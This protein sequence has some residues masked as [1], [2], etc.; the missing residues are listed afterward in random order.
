MTIFKT[1][2]HT[3]EDALEGTTQKYWLRKYDGFLMLVAWILLNGLQAALTRLDPDEAYYWVYAQALEWGYFDHPPAVAVLIWLGKSLL[4][5][6]LGVR[7]FTVLLMVGTLYGMWILAGKPQDRS[8]LT[9]LAALLV[10]MPFLHIYSFVATPDAPLLFC[11]VW[12]FVCYQRFVKDASWLNTALLG[13][14]MAAMLFSKYHGLLV[15]LFTL[16]SNWRLLLQPRFY[17]ASVFGAVLFLPH[18]YWQ[19]AHDFPSFRYHLSGRDDPYELKHTVTYV[20]NQLVIFN[21]F[22]FPMLL[23]A[24]IRHPMRNTLH[25]PFSFL[26]IGFWGFFF[27]TTFKGHVEPQW[28]MLLLIPLVLTGYHFGLQSSNY[29]RWVMRFAG[30]SLLLL[31]LARIA[32]LQWN[33]FQL[34]TDFHRTHWVGELQQVVQGTPVVFQNSY[35]DPSVYA[36]YSGERAYTFTDANYRRNQFDIFDWEKVL[37]GQRVAIA[38]QGGW[39]C[40]DCE[41]VALTRKTIRL[42]FADSLQIA[43][44][45]H[46]HFSSPS[47]WKAG[48][49]VALKLTLHNPYSH[50]IQPTTGNM[51]L[52]LRTVFYDP[53]TERISATTPLAWPDQPSKWLPQA[54]ITTTVTF[55]VPD[56]LSGIYLF[57]IGV[58]TGELPPPFSSRPVLINIVAPPQQ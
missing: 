35:R 7:L 33:P 23:W 28:T 21:P 2:Q 29:R 50:E 1:A 24:V 11:A 43:Q 8:K 37:H 9:L 13:L 41:T 53:R 4:T 44:K 56:E 36:F 42:K 51:P 12:F 48:E 47:T 18:L 16:F 40:T 5:N 25:R 27:Y 10:S 57:A 20:L 30:L 58:Q 22:L 39:A 46:I 52:T 15:I 3:P 38:G 34:K 54:S 45:V 49:E 14:S 6:E 19:Y 17:I 32:L 26:L 55:V 31:L